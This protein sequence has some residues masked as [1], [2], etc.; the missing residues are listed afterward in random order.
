MSEGQQFAVSVKTVSWLQGPRVQERAPGPGCQRRV[1]PALVWLRILLGPDLGIWWGLEPKLWPK[2]EQ[3][4]QDTWGRTSF[5]P[6]ACS[7]KGW[8]RGP[9]PGPVWTRRSGLDSSSLVRSV[10]GCIWPPA[11]GNGFC[12]LG[13]AAP[14]QLPQP[15][16][17]YWAPMAS[18]QSLGGLRLRGP[19]VSVP[20]LS[21]SPPG[22][23]WGAGGS[24][25]VPVMEVSHLQ[26]VLPSPPAADGV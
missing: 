9:G 2:G 22:C 17:L 18:G 16:C 7:G 12:P 21:A 20:I 8:R 6:Q 10:T 25:E 4:G 5:P 14:D 19:R 13:V 26:P 24:H 11:T 15:W 23:S 3:M 1:L